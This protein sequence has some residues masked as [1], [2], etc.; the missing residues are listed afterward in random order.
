[1]GEEEGEGVIKIMEERLLSFLWDKCVFSLK[2]SF[3]LWLNQPW[4]SWE[5]T[6]LS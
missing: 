3:I 1:M 5:Q 2:F 6:L 4:L